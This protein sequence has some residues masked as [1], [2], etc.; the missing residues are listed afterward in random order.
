MEI[1]GTRA[2]ENAL[3]HNESYWDRTLDRFSRDIITIEH[4]PKFQFSPVNRFFCLGSCFARNIEESLLY[5]QIEVTSKRIICPRAEWPARPNGLVNKF[6]T[7]SILN[8]V[9]W[10]LH[11]DAKMEQSFLQDNEG[12]V[13]LQ[14]CPG[15]SPV[16]QERATERRRYLSHDYFARI[17]N[18]DVVIITL[19]LIEAW[20]DKQSQLFLNKPPSF[21]QVRREPERFSLHTLSANDNLAAL[22][23][24]RAIIKA[25]N[26]AA[27]FIIT[28]SPV[29]MGMTFTGCDVLVA[30]TL[31]KS[32]LRAAAESF[33]ERHPDA[34][35]FPAYE[36]ITQSRRDVVYRSDCIHVTFDAVSAVV[37]QFCNLYLPDAPPAEEGFIEQRYL[38]ANP[39]V[40]EAVRAGH[41]GSGFEHWVDIGRAEGL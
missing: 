3:E 15:A 31:S 10:A 27:R 28:V 41:L 8:E 21:W 20:Y 16:S 2:Y 11:S 37:A 18:S 6:T 9:R 34:D 1:S 14:L 17:R 36:L 25:A 13:D 38:D 29:P 23:D 40:E 32:A 5:R 22:E 30:N 4:R 35:Y 33:C 39:D 7:H 24:V 26:P 12:W 19:G